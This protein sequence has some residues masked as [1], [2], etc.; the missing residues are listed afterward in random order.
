MVLVQGIARQPG[1]AGWRSFSSR[2][3]AAQRRCIGY[4]RSVCC[5]GN[6]VFGYTY[7]TLLRLCSRALNR[8]RCEPTLAL[9]VGTSVS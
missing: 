9:R 6:E 7:A 1:R 5:A 8:F 4:Q 3:R 2:R